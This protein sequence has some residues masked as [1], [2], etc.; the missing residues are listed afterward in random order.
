MPTTP[1]SQRRISR[2]YR[3][4]IGYDPL[5]ATQLP[6][7]DTPIT[8]PEAVQILREFREARDEAPY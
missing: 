6:E 7:G 1:A 2:L 4:W 8:E 5:D 3:N